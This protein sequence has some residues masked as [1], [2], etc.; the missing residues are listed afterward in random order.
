MKKISTIFILLLFHVFGSGQN[1]KPNFV[2]FIAD[3][4]SWDDLGCYGNQD[5]KTPNIDRLAR[6]GIRFTNVYLTASSCSPSR[7]S[8]MTGRYPHNTGAAELHTEPPLDMISLPGILKTQGYFTAQ[9]GKFHMGKYIEPSFDVISR[10]SEETGDGGEKSWTKI[11]QKRPKQKPFF[12]WYAAH[13]AHRAWGPNAFSGTHDPE[14]ITP[15]FY[16]MNGKE[17]K[18][19]LAKYYDEIKRF[20][21]FIGA[22]IEELETQEV[23]D[24]TLIIV[25]ADNGRPF[26]HSKTRA[27]DRGMK[28]PFVL[29]WPAVIKKAALC[30]SLV[31]VI[32]IAPTLARLADIETPPSF[33]GKSFDNLLTKPMEPFRSYVFAEHNWHD[34]EAHERMVRS[35]DFMYI[36]NSRPSQP[37]MGPADAVG[38]PSFKDLKII[39]AQ[40]RLTAIQADIFV[41]PRPMEELYQCQKDP[42]QLLNV[43][44]VPNQQQALTHMRQILDQWMKETGDDIPAILTPDW[45]LHESGYI[46]TSVHG[47]RGTMP[48]TKTNAS[49]NH[50]KGPF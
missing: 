3:D 49:E 34:Y 35:T 48:G 2:I 13:D 19:D 11:L 37:Q 21:H 5:V 22:V 1:S 32:D 43:A 36:L 18:E 31:S 47:K 15:P 30:Q 16:L 9:S 45:Y 14:E 6:D 12:C 20:D 46:R 4:V 17:T 42:L 28:T 26:P 8:I 24:Q 44:S 40:G 39:H 50:N 7:N 33:Q 29:H 38:S 27:N 41:T 25:M 23:L 10:T